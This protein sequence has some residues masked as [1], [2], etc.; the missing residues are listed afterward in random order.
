MRIAMLSEH[1]SPL[2][3]VGGVDA[4]G[5]NV[6]V[7]ALAESLAL[8]GNDV[9][10]YTRRDSPD[11][12]DSIEMAPGV[13]VEHL[14]AGP[15]E[16]IG[17]DDL[18]PYLPA[19][20]V[21]LASGLRE[22]RPGVLHAH[23]WM[24][25]QVAACAA[26]L[27]GIPV[28]QTFHALGTVKRRWQGAADT[29]PRQRIGVERAVARCA[30]RIIATCTDEVRELV[31][32]GADRSRIDVVPSGVDIGRFRPD[33]PVAAR[34]RR[35]RLLS[36]GRLVPRKGVDDAIAALRW[37]PDAELVIAGGSEPS[38]ASGDRETRQLRECAA[39][40]GVLDRVRFI[41]RVPRADL[42]A[43][44]RSSDLVVCMPWYEP[45]GIVPIE[46]MACGVPVVA[47]AV[48]GLL[49]TVIDQVTG[50]LLPPRRPRT[51][52]ETICAL[53]A[54][55]DRRRALGRAGAE[56]ARTHYD[57]SRLAGL[58]ER[59]YLRALATQP[60]A[61]PSSEVAG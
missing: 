28:L 19:L 31:S 41:G 22:K 9:V 43:L 18:L 14:R 32:L 4:G 7:A 39:S 10:V 25:G 1:A 60:A 23:F 59:S 17:K 38:Q 50:V 42:P 21:E 61:A 16:P 54:D 45:F 15:P 44:I 55:P 36:V 53:L 56:R 6:H 46:A 5:Q 35:P 29:S 30:T 13:T 11:L 48:G 27:L 2:A 24:S 37:V 58:T 26:P 40:H 51:L 49:D 47:S 33:G 52:G 3:A 8:R 20:A 57:W 34:S 12:P